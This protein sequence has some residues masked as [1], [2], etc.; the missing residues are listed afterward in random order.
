MGN[1]FSQSKGFYSSTTSKETSKN[2]KKCEYCQIGKWKFVGTKVGKFQ[3]YCNEC[4]KEECFEEI[5]G[6]SLD[7]IN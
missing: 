4:Q 7:K 5:Y 2:E 6:M 3:H 1:R